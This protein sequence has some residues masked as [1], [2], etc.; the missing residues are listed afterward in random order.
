MQTGEMM[1]SYGKIEVGFWLNRKVQNLTDDAK[2]LLLYLLSCQHGNSLGCFVLPEGYITADLKWEP[3]RVSKHVSE[4]VSKGFI[5]HDETVSLVRICGWFGH[6]GFENGNV[7]KA[8]MK[9]LKML[10]PCAVK[11]CLINELFDIGNKFINEY[12]NEFENE[13]RN[14]KPNLTQPEPEPNQEGEGVPDEPPPP[15]PPKESSSKGT[16]LPKD[17]VLPKL[18]GEWAVTEGMQPEQVRKEASKFSDHW[19]STAGQKAV[20]ADWE[21]TWRNWIRRAIEDKRTAKGGFQQS[22][23]RKSNVKTL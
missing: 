8:A 6:N 17:W 3:K 1:R 23:P 2:L 12:R 15:P 19:H 4:L 18:W 21:A 11:S 22:T 13:L 9:A 16:R 14:P 5:D 10:P 20:K 7:A